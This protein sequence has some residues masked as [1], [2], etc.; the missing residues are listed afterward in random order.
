MKK[1]AKCRVCGR[2]LKSNEHNICSKCNE[3]I[4]VKI[5]EERLREGGLD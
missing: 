4:N 3:K 1:K 5:F 2:Y